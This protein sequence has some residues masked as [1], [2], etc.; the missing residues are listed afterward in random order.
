M[1][2]NLVISC[3]KTNLSKI[4]SFLSEIMEEQAIAE[5]E[6]HKMILAVDEICANL[7]IHS[8]YCNPTKKIEILVNFE[9]PTKV[10]FIIKDTGISFDFDQYKEP[11]MTDIIS[12]KRKGGVGLILVKRIMDKIEFSTDKNYNI[13]RLTKNIR[14]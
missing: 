11:D 9:T 3:N 10:I 5:L 2:H 14:T 6:A 13:C 7:I 12:S 8:N 1:K 4:R